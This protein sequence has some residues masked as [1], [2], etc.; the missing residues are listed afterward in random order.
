MMATRIGRA[1]LV[2]AVL[3]IILLLAFAITPARNSAFSIAA[4]TDVIVVEPSCSDQLTWDLPPGWVV[5]DGAPLDGSDPLAQPAALVT[6]KLAAGARAT[7]TR[8][9]AGYWKMRFTLDSAFQDCQPAP[10][11]PLSVTVGGERLPAD[12][13]GYSYQS[14][15]GEDPNRTAVSSSDGSRPQ[16]G[17]APPLVLRLAG[18]MVLGQ[19]ISEGGGWGGASQ[20]ILHGARVEVR[21]KAW[22]TNQSLSVLVEDI[23]SGG[24]IDTHACIAEDAAK[25]TPPCVLNR[26]G[27]SAGFL[28]YPT[29]DGAMFAQVHRTT[30]R[31]GVVPYGGVERQLGVTNWAI[32]VKSPMLQSI[33]AALL[34]ISALLQGWVAFQEMWSRMAARRNAVRA[35]D[36]AGS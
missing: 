5:A 4:T 11:S 10:P 23:G 9:A 25:V 30:S 15:Y 7:V 28:Y 17:P 21:D 26:P 24:L 35:G 12:P 8:E 33:V 27:A 1:L 6:V 31:I 2:I 3:A 16:L 14:S 18:R 29:N 36:D 19:P 20:P 32:L 22:L 13:T 34:L